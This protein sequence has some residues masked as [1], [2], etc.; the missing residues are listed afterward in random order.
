MA[1]DQSSSNEERLSPE[2][3]DL[4]RFIENWIAHAPPALAQAA[5]YAALVHTFDPALLSFLRDTEEETELLIA[6]LERAGLIVV[7]SPNRYSFERILR[8]PYLRLWQASDPEMYR[9]ESARAAAHYQSRQS[10]SEIDRIEHV[11]HLLGADDELGLHALIQEIE[12][13]WSAR[14]LGLVERL[15]QYADEQTSVL[16]TSIRTWLR[17]FQA[18]LELAHYHYVRSEEILR[19]IV[20]SDTEPRLRAEAL[21]SL[22]STLVATQRWNEA[23]NSFD[24]AHGIFLQIN[25]RFKAA[26][27]LKAQGEAYLHLVSSL[28]SLH[29]DVKTHQPH[30]QIWLRRVALFP[31]LLYR[32]LSRRIG[33][34]PSLYFGTDYQDWIIFR[35]IYEAIHHFEQASRQLARIRE[36]TNP[37]G[38]EILTDLQ[39]YLADLYH[40]VGQ[41][42]KAAR[43]FESLATAATVSDY[44]RATLQLARGRAALT[45]SSLIKAREYLQD[46]RKVFTQYNDLRALA[47]TTRL[48]GDTEVA[49]NKLNAA[50]PFYAESAEVSLTVDD[51][52]ESTH[53]WSAIRRIQEHFSFSPDAKSQI[54]ALEQKLNRRAY[55]IRFRSALLQRF[56]NL[57]ARLA[58]YVVLPLVYLVML[59]TGFPG[60]R[61]A[62]IALMTKFTCLVMPS[63]DTLFGDL[64]GSVFAILA[65]LLLAIWAYGF[66]YIFMGW[67]SV[68]L[69]PLGD[70]AQLQTEF[71]V[72]FPTG[73]TLRD[74]TGQL[75]ELPWD[76]V[77]SHIS[78][79]HAI[80]RVP[81]ALFSRQFLISG[82]TPS[83]IEGIA[84]HYQSLQQDI[85]ERLEWAKNKAVQH[86]FDYAFF[87]GPW[88]IITLLL[89]TGM[90]SISVSDWFDQTLCRKPNIESI[91][92]RERR[93]V[94]VSTDDGHLHVVYVQPEPFQID[95]VGSYDTPGQGFGVTV[96][97]AYAYIADGTE[98]LRIVDVRDPTNPVEVGSYNTPGQ[99]MGVAVAGQYAYVADGTEGLRI[100]DVRDPTNP[101]EVGSYNTPG[102]ASGI[103]VGRS[104][105]Y[106]ADGT[107]GLRII[108][109][110]DLTSPVEVGSYDTPGQ[111]FGVTVEGAYAYIADGTEGLRIVDVSGPTDPV[112]VS[113]YDTPGQATDVTVNGNI[114]YVADGT[115]GLRV[116]FLRDPDATSQVVTIEEA[117]TNVV[118]MP[119]LAFIADGTRGLLVI[120]VLNP[121]DDD[122]KLNERPKKYFAME[123]FINGMAVPEVITRPI[124]SISSELF[125]WTLLFF[126]IIG[127][128]RL[129]YNRAS[130]RHIDSQ[131][132]L[133]ADWPF[134]LALILLIALA[135]FHTWTL[136]WS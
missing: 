55:I 134:W 20:T 70:I 74:E 81:I 24:E 39:I 92:I 2:K 109:A 130:L 60:V 103:A 8:Q 48:L 9:R 57:A 65:P 78:A 43:L 129:L 98:G 101:V 77:E 52:L 53:I 17:L 75:R 104:Y 31:F 106:I 12:H 133:G 121:C 13:I 99:A 97:G 100:V 93:L 110:R 18:R 11:Y 5:R 27:A 54:D 89:V 33:L 38:A 49:S 127:L 128:A 34:I 7:V 14:R 85:T 94:Y 83:I 80:W 87:T 64:V 95:I 67:I 42:T 6:R 41:W 124:A 26:C 113:F 29:Q 61:P 88:T 117:A 50:I 114:A 120:D 132:V 68:R 56:R 136:T 30:Y 123:R 32:W 73:I 122:F 102:Q 108:S 44:R 111:A 105:I 36:E 71:V 37:P 131:L 135:V 23:K 21:M 107:A 10:E 25:D 86:A 69:L 59:I 22:A 40:R 3:D 72:T 66:F 125:F 47:T 116:V 58:A 76:I 46:A 16:G 35:L 91:D 115:Q 82:E 112:E 119:D 96:E 90:T 45:Q 126:P 1:S 62:V 15:L 84:H 118:L 19:S 79:N 51:L 63:C 28:G 4:Q